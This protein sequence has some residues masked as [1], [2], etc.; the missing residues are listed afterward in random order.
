MTVEDCLKWLGQCSKWIHTFTILMIW[1]R[2]VSCFRMVLRCHYISLSEPGANELLH[3]VRAWQNSSFEKGA[4][5]VVGLGSISLRT[6][7]SISRW[8]AELNV[9]W[10]ASQRLSVVMHRFLL[11]L[12]A[13]VAGS[14]R[15]LTQFINFHGLQ[16]LLATSWILVSKNVLLVSFTTLLNFFQLSRLL[17]ALYSL[18]ARLHSLFHHCLE[19]LVILDCFVFLFYTWLISE[20][21]LLTIFSRHSLLLM[22]R[23]SRFWKTEMTSL[24]KAFSCLLFCW[25]ESFEVVINSFAMGIVTDRGVWFNVS[26]QSGWMEC[27]FN[28]IES[29]LRNT[30]VELVFP[31]VSEYLV[32]KEVVDVE[33]ANWKESA[34]SNKSSLIDEWWGNE[35]SHRLS[36][37]LKS[38]VI[39]RMLSKLTS[40]SLRY[41]KAV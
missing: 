39:T 19:C 8:R 25:I 24:M 2:H 28:S 23:V 15:L 17:D 37:M 18:M 7:L 32:G 14:L 29:H 36:L 40:I 5:I 9:A 33:R 34:I 11:Y 12:M 1:A 6:S 10:R 26:R 38:L 35:E 30:M 41:F 3:L 22:L 13:S 16:L 4:Q 27:W 31:T 21:R 20:L